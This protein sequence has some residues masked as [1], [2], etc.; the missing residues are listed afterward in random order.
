MNDITTH[1]THNKI[2][3][4]PA[5]CPNSSVKGLIMRCSKQA[6]VPTPWLL[7]FNLARA[8]L[9]R[10]C[11]KQLGN[12]GSEELCVRSVVSFEDKLQEGKDGCRPLFRERRQDTACKT[13]SGYE[14]YR[15]G[16][17]SFLRMRKGSQ[18]DGSVGREGKLSE[19][20]KRGGVP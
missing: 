5:L 1:T 17:P 2:E 7:P 13:T 10:G 4:K 8:V 9:R 19:Y 14:R 12:H 6:T 20:C 15:L 16:D 11:I 3:L 18:E